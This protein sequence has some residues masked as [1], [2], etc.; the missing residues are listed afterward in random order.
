MRP[1]PW[2]R[3]RQRAPFAGP[4]RSRLRI[5]KETEGES[6]YPQP[7]RIDDLEDDRVGFG[8]LPGHRIGGGDDA[9]DGSNQPLGLAARLVE[10]SA[11]LPQSLELEDGLIERNLG[12]G[13]GL[14]EGFV[15]RDAPLD[16][17]DLLIEFAPLLAHVGNIDGLEWRRHQRQ[18]IARLHDGAKPRKSA[19]GRRKAAADRRLH[20]PARIRIGDD[21]PRQLQGLAVGGGLR[22]RRA[23]GQNALR[24]L[25]HEQRAVGKPL[26]DFAGWLK[27]ALRGAI[28]TLV[29][30]RQSRREQKQRKKGNCQRS[31]CDRPAQERRRDQ[32]GGERNQRHKRGAAGAKS[33]FEPLRY[34]GGEDAPPAALA[35]FRRSRRDVERAG[36]D[37]CDVVCRDRE[38]EVVRTHLRPRRGETIGALFG[39]RFNRTERR[40]DGNQCGRDRDIGFEAV[41]IDDQLALLEKGRKLERARSGFKPRGRAHQGSGRL[42]VTVVMAL[43]RRGAARH[44]HHGNERRPQGRKKES[45]GKAFSRLSGTRV[46][47]RRKMRLAARSMFRA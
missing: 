34:S 13:A 38:D 1:A 29:R 46:F 15:A 18:H 9:R 40:L 22:E 25:G 42:L 41:E 14:G 4:R 47:R 16:D 37:L 39:L 26:R 5:G 10:R 19:L 20:E 3:E 8:D 17:I 27:R 24:G 35:G 21:A 11:A 23:N 36:K 12:H 33:L 30:L 6:L 7:R 44:E 32:T 2:K 31:L 45:H 28:M 43:V